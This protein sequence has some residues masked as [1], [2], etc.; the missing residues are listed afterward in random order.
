M[1]REIVCIRCSEEAVAFGLV[2]DEKCIP[3]H[4]EQGYRKRKACGMLGR[5]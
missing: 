3:D 1:N 4:R 5:A 2:L